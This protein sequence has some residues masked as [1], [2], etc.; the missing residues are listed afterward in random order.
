MS[1]WRHLG[2]KGI[3]FTLIIALALMS[4][5]HLALAQT[6]PA[7]TSDATQTQGHALSDAEIDQAIADLVSNSFRVRQDAF[8][9]LVSGGQSCVARLESAASTNDLETATRCVEAIVQIAGMK[10]CAEVAI[11]SLERLAADPASRVALRAKDSAAKLK[12]TDEERAVAGL[13]ADGAEIHRGGDGDVYSVTLTTRR[14][15]RWL[16]HLP[17]PRS[18]QFMGKGITDDC[19][20]QIPASDRLTSLSFIDTALTDDGLARLHRLTGLQRLHFSTGDFSGAGVRHLRNT[21]TLKQITVSSPV[22]HDVLQALTELRQVESMSFYQLEPDERAITLLSQLGHL[23]RMTLAVT[24]VDDEVLRLLGQ[25]RVPTDLNCYNS[26]KVTDEGWKHLEGARLIALRTGT[27]EITDSNLAAISRLTTLERLAIASSSITEHGLRHLAGL[28]SLKWLQISGADISEDAMS[29]LRRELPKLQIRLAPAVARAAVQRP[30]QPAIHL[31]KDSVT[32]QNA[33]VR[34]P[35]TAALAGEL[36]AVADLQTVF[37]T[38]SNANDEGLAFLRDVSLKGVVIDSLNVTDRGIQ[39]LQDHPTLESVQLWSSSISDRSLKAIARIPSLKK[40]Y[41]KKA[42]I[43]DSGLSDLISE[44]SE[45]GQIESLGLIE[46]HDL[47]NEGLEK[48]CELASLRGL[49]LMGNEGLTSR[50]FEYIAELKNLATLSVHDLAISESDLVFLQSLTKL[51]TIRLTQS[52]RTLTLTD[53]A[54]ESISRLH[55]L[56]SLTIDN[57]TIE[58]SSL[59][60]LAALQGLVSLGLIRTGVGDEGISKVTELFPNLTLLDM[61]G[62]NVSDEGMAHVGKLKKLERLIVENTDVGDVG[63]SH[64]DE[65]TELKYVVLSSDNVSDFGQQ[66]FRERHPDTQLRL[67]EPSE[68]QLGR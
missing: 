22:S 48:I 54:L 46:C 43:T 58:D 60:Q 67:R 59:S 63:L 13:A 55:S 68:G 53:E 31:M 21:S 51:E 15:F 14:Q 37:L 36:K 10:D 18:L 11:A 41:I 28:K 19:I 12:M 61:S 6:K 65:L 56:K 50:S 5:P 2:I 25:L 32:G 40:L 42:K 7:S 1:S 62:T 44:L 39:A 57:A 16:K 66:Q 64:L 23:K 26:D 17:M 27:S 47:T 52:E 45:K 8:E 49:S 30:K 35:L 38:S 9:R 34:E 29:E 20:N 24:K 3:R 33:H 4:G